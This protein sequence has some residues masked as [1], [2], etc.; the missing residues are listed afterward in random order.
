LSGQLAIYAYLEPVYAPGMRTVSIAWIKPLSAST[1][2]G[3]EALFDAPSD[4]S[5]T[6]AKSSQFLRK[7]LLTASLLASASAFAPNS[8]S[9]A[10]SALNAGIVETIGS[11]QGPEI[12]WGSEGVEQGFDEAD[13]KGYDNFTKLAAALAD[14][15]LTGA[16]YTVL[17][18][19]DSAIDKHLALGEAITADVLKYHVILGKKTLDQLNSDQ[20]TLQGGTLTSYRKFRKNWL[21]FAIVGLKSE[22]ASKSA[23][24][25]SDV[26]ADN[27]L[28]H[29]IDT[30]LIPGAYTGSR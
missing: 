28:I 20:E 21:D 16:D 15:D 3:Q 27:G 14:V 25:P 2:D 10:S 17:A 4:L 18:P 9:P 22:G 5:P 1:S 13:I 12:F 29:A 11:M 30:V 19:S 26:E 24:W 8:G 6:M 23:S 7:F